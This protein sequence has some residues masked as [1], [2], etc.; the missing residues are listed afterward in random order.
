MTSS[1]GMRMTLKHCASHRLYVISVADDGG[2]GVGHTQHTP[3]PH[4]TEPSFFTFL[5]VSVKAKLAYAF[6]T[7][8]L[9]SV[10]TMNLLL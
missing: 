8:D 4:F 10:F 5:Y 9:L 2:G 6:T 1:H 3:L 7:I